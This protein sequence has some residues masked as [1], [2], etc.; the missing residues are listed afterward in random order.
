M[1]LPDVRSPGVVGPEF[2]RLVDRWIEP[3]SRRER[4]GGTPSRRRGDRNREAIPAEGRSP[5]G[6]AREDLQFHSGPHE[7]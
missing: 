1:G 6:G 2:S 4:E 5:L 7:L 3:L